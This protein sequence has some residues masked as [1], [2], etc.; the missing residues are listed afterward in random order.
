MCTTPSKLLMKPSV[1][2]KNLIQTIPQIACVV[3]ALTSFKF[4]SHYIAGHT[5]RSP[6]ACYEASATIPQ[7]VTASGLK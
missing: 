2:E 4:P 5:D 7:S 3:S 1:F 6:H